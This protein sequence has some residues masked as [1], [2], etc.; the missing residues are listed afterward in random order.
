MWYWNDWEKNEGN[1]YVMKETTIWRSRNEILIDSG[2]CCNWGIK[3][4]E[5]LKCN[6]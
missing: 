4:K 2:N 5:G 3:T 6:K 1:V